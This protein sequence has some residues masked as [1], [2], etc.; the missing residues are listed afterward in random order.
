M[1][2]PKYKFA[3]FYVKSDGKN[4]FDSYFDQF[5]IFK[6]KND[7]YGVTFTSGESNRLSS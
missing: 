2:T 5:Q 1:E 3:L 7:I 6:E 4:G